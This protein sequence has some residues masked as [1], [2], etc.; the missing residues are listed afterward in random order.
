MCIYVPI[1]VNTR[2][3]ADNDNE[4]LRLIGVGSARGGCFVGRCHP[5]DDVD[6]DLKLFSANDL[7]EKGL[8][9]ELFDNMPKKA[10]VLPLPP[11][12]FGCVAAVVTVV[13]KTADAAISDRPNRNISI[14]KLENHFAYQSSKTPVSRPWM[15]T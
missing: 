4:S 3:A 11:R 6:T 14:L 2:A 12:I 8:R 9:M 15:T 10:S 13:G 7:L 5:V 1:V